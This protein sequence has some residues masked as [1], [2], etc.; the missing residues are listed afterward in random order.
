MSFSIAIS[1]ST[2]DESWNSS[3]DVCE[4]AHRLG[5]LTW[6]T[7]VLYNGIIEASYSSQ[8]PPLNIISTTRSP[9]GRQL[10]SLIL[11]VSYLL[12]GFQA[13]SYHSLISSLYSHT[14]AP[15][16]HS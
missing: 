13:T 8:A 16:T 2:E 3:F 4:C 12:I 1:W 10:P 11:R 14:P 6:A 9:V 7:W 15:F 5:M